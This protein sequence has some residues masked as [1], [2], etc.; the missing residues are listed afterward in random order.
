MIGQKKNTAIAA[1]LQVQK[2]ALYKVDLRKSGLG[3]RMSR[4]GETVVG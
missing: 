3:T 4:L 2:S 1:K